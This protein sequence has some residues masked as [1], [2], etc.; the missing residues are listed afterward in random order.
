MSEID[1]K[2]SIE[3]LERVYNSY[4]NGEYSIHHPNGIGARHYDHIWY[5]IVLGLIKELRENDDN[6]A[7][8]F[9]LRVEFEQ[10]IAVKRSLKHLKHKARN[11]KVGACPYCGSSQY[12]ERKT[13][14]PRFRC[15]SCKQNFDNLKMRAPHNLSQSIE[16]LE[17]KQKSKDYSYTS[18]SPNKTLGPIYPFIYDEALRIYNETVKQIVSDYED[19]KEVTV[20]CRKCHGAAEMGLVICEKCKTNYHREHN[21]ACIRCRTGKT[22][23]EWEEELEGEWEEDLEAELEEDFGKDW[24]KELKSLDEI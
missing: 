20:L 2:D 16:R 9:D 15:T 3:E 13:L 24:K 22:W 12:N 23:I 11:S 10:K 18:V 17:A 5:T 7:K 6:F 21:K 19:M 14:T 4:K 1:R 8:L